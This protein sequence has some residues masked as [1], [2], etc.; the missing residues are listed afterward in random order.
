MMITVFIGVLWFSI[1]S[2]TATS[3]SITFTW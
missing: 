3:Q 2:Q 1:C